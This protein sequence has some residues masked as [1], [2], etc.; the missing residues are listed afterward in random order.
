MG[1]RG[2]F[3]GEGPGRRNPDRYVPFCLSNNEPA[4]RCGA[5]KK[6][7]VQA[8]TGSG[9]FIIVAENLPMIERTA[10]EHAE[11]GSPDLEVDE[12]LA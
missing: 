3:E 9:R 10:E 2:W 4:P 11:A 1:E 5:Y 6:R 7:G 8:I 12:F